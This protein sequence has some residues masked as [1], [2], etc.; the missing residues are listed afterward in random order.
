[1]ISLLTCC[2]VHLQKQ[3]TP[4]PSPSYDIPADHSD[5]SLSCLVPYHV[6]VSWTTEYQK[7]MMKDAEDIAAL[8]KQLAER[9]NSLT[10]LNQTH[11][12][13]LL[14]QQKAY[15]ELV[16]ANKTL[17]EKLSANVADKCIVERELASS[18]ATIV[19]LERTV[20]GYRVSSQVMTHIMLTHPMI[21]P[22][23]PSYQPIL[24]TCAVT[25]P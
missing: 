18:L 12:Q 13:Q 16:I 10:T 11:E 22:C 6:H 14:R 8:R 19:G 3:V 15:D 23:T 21:I 2:L 9:P 17:E 24:S 20:E 25:I 4:L 5:I 1:M 7:Q